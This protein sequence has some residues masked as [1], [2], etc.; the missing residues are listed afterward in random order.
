LTTDDQVRNTL[1]DLQIKAKAA[2]S[3]RTDPEI[4]LF[5][6]CHDLYDE[7]DLYDANSTGGINC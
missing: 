6:A 4:N 7:Y 1:I 3:Y 2:N 5:T